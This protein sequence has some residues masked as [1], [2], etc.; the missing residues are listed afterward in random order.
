MLFHVVAGVLICL[1]AGSENLLLNP[2][3]DELNAEGLPL[4]WDLFVMPMEGAEGRVVSEESGASVALLHNPQAYIEEPANNWSQILVGDDFEGKTLLLSAKVKTEEAGE[5]AVWL[6][7]FRKNPARV[8][9][10][11]TTST[12]TPLSGT[13]DWTHLTLDAEV[14]VGTDFIVVRCVLKGSGT[15]W[16]DEMSMIEVSEP[17]PESEA[18]ESDIANVDVGRMDERKLEDLVALR[19]SMWGA[20]EALRKTNTD[21]KE[22]I[23]TLEEQLDAVRQTLLEVDTLSPET[24]PIEPLFGPHPLVPRG[25]NEEAYPQ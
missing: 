14:P 1:V 10:A 8:L 16:F 18:D 4:R 23:G 3:F 6:Q 22:Q 13:Q 25:H 9:A 17:D 12:S 5:A 7:C 20:I 2:G 15:A 24:V 19:E 11:W 21:M